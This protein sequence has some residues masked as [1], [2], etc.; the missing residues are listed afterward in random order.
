MGKK[1]LKDLNDLG[2]HVFSDHKIPSNRREFL[3]SGVMGLSTMALVSPLALLPEDAFAQQCN[4]TADCGV[5]FF[6][7]EG[8]GGMNIPGGNVMVGFGADEDQLNFGGS[9]SMTD[10]IR[11]GLP[12]DMHPSRPGML[13]S[14]YGL[15][16]HSTS[17]LLQGLEEVLTPALPT[18]P[19]Y[20]NSI[21]GLL[22]CARTGDDSSDNPV[23]CGF[24]AQK[25]GARGKLVQLIG[26]FNSDTGGRSP[27]VST[28]IRSELRSSRITRFTEASGLLSL[29][30]D[31]M[32]TTFLDAAAGGG[33][34][35]VKGF[36]NRILNLSQR[37]L[38]YFVNQQ[39][40]AQTLATAQGGTK[41][42]FDRF[43]PS[44][45]NPVNQPAE[46]AMLQEAFGGMNTD[47]DDENVASVAHLVTDRIAGVGSITVGGCDYHNGTAASGQ[48][49]D[50]QIGRYIGKV[51]KLA[52]LK[53]QNI[54]VHLYTDGGVGG[55]NGGTIEDTPEGAGRVIWTNDSGT[56]SA[57]MILV[58]KHGWDRT[59]DPSI[60]I[61][62]AQG[63]EKKRQI[64]FFNQAGGIN[65]GSSSIAA[66]TDSIWKAV[67]LNYM[68]CMSTA[69]G[70]PAIHA[71]VENRWRTTFPNETL[72]DDWRE[73]IRL[74]PLV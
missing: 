74:R 52:A 47:V 40:E 68:S 34:A 32:N 56:R 72:P 66:S 42:L 20:R 57:Q 69:V 50:R 6:S 63:N 5:P 65:N 49:R 61:T 43:S 33:T 10:Y 35:R 15:V 16:F 27:A 25:A 13:N 58:Y 29:G 9:Q 45:L 53:G 3:A 22:I 14:T 7:V 17:G 41:E 67:I 73:L 8:A 46:L 60:L 55:A 12:P 31:I 71:D 36:L 4:T 24:Q 2:I 28:Q 18:D 62:D 54:F 37:R 38:D 44:S 23:H 59:S 11:L 39:L 19:D 30:S 26:G 21:D 48:N 51:I 64:G 70:D 1:K